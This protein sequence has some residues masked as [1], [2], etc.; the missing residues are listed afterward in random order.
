MNFIDVNV[1]NG[2]FEINGHQFEANKQ[3]NGE[4]IAAI[5]AEK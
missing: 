1:I 5:R 3:I 2:K 4:V